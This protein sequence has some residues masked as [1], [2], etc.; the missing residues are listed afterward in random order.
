VSQSEHHR[1]CS[2]LSFASRRLCDAEAVRVEVV[3]THNEFEED[4]EGDEESEEQ[5]I[6]SLFGEIGPDD[7][8]G[9][10]RPDFFC[11]CFR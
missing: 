6:L 9:R 11:E 7:A 10:Q 3:V 5:L 1:Q 4:Y 8:E 2:G